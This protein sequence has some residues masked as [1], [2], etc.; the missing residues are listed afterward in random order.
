M[1][2][3]T[4]A[5]VLIDKKGTCLCIS[6]NSSLRPPG[7]GSRI[8]IV[9]YEPR[10]TEGSRPEMECQRLRNGYKKA[11]PFCTSENAFKKDI[12]DLLYCL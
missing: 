7:A 11:L 12:S 9:K 2:A 4:G 5:L 3:Y 8:K 10:L 6:T 1:P